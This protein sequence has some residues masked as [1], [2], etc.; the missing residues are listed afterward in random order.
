[1]GERDRERGET[2]RNQRHESERRNKEVETFRERDH[3]RGTW[4]SSTDDQ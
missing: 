3:K 2:V 4:Y 1:M